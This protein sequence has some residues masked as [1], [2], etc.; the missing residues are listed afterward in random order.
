M[1]D[2]QPAELGLQMK[3]PWLMNI[4]GAKEVASQSICKPLAVLWACIPCCRKHKFSLI[5]SPSSP[6]WVTNHVGASWCWQGWKPPA[7]SMV[8]LRQ[9]GIQGPLQLWPGPSAEVLMPAWQCRTRSK[10]WALRFMVGEGLWRGGGQHPR[11]AL[12]QWQ[13]KPLFESEGLS[14][15]THSVESGAVPGHISSREVPG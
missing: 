11:T 2:L 13:R 4:I 6:D 9:M 1:F 10:R 14:R 3:T 8:E 5:T 7:G 15:G 12:N